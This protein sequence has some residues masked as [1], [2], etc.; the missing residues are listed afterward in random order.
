MQNRAMASSLPHFHCS[1]DPEVRLHIMNHLKPCDNRPRVSDLSII[2]SPAPRET[3]VRDVPFQVVTPAH[4]SYVCDMLKAG[5][6]PQGS[7]LV[8]LFL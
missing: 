8:P 2:K 3:T 7:L 5:G 4:V 6:V 1:L